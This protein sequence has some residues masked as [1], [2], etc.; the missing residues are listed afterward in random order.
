MA[1]VVWLRKL[2]QA[3]L[4]VSGDEPRYG[5]SCGDRD[6]LQAANTLERLQ[7]L[8]MLS[9]MKPGQG[10][11]AGPPFWLNEDPVCRIYRRGSRRVRR[12]QSLDGAACL[13]G[14]KA[15]CERACHQQHGQ[16]QPHSER[17]GSEQES[18]I[19]LVWPAAPPLPAPT[20]INF[21][22]VRKNKVPSAIAGVA[23]Q[24][25]CSS[26]EAASEYWSAAANTK[27]TPCSLVK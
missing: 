25:S 15:E 12:S 14:P 16:P 1:E 23:R 24:V 18:H 10:F 27:T 21:P 7:Y 4:L 6:D 26:L 5:F 17:R 3:A 8:A 19:Q 11:E 22:R 20:A 13:P 9:G 2:D